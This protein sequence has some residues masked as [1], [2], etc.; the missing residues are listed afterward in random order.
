GSGGGQGWGGGGRGLGD[1]AWGFAASANVD[2]AAAEA[3]ARNAV[4]IAHAA[5]SLRKH[6]VELAPAPVVRGGWQTPMK[7]D[8]FEVPLAEKAEYLLAL[9]P[10]VKDV[11]RVKYATAS[12]EALGEHKIF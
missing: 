9:W 1:G 12:F 8:P 10:V 6:P 2:G 11:P 5:R 7:V 4:A 3:A